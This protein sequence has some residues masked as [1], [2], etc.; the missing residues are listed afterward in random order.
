MFV[1]DSPSAVGIACHAVDQ[2]SMSARINHIPRL[3]VTALYMIVT[4]WPVSCTDEAIGFIV[5]D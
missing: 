1:I 4:S 2:G 5:F 3:T